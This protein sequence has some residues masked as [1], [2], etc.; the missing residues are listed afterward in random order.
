MAPL[1]R[2]VTPHRGGEVWSLHLM[3]G[4]D[5]ADFAEYHSDHIRAERDVFWLDEPAPHEG[6]S[7]PN[8]RP[9]FGVTLNDTML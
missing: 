4:S 5:W 6:H 1:V 7:S 9:G 2:R 8:D 3:V